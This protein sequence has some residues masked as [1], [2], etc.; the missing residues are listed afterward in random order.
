MGRQCLLLF[1]VMSLQI[2]LS[3]FGVNNL[4][5]RNKMYQ[6]TGTA[7]LVLSKLELAGSVAVHHSILFSHLSSGNYLLASMAHP[8]NGEQRTEF[9]CGQGYGTG[10]RDFGKFSCLVSYL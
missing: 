6:D 1:F 2:Q 5:F 4:S 10:V 9:H 3:W 8:W 7:V